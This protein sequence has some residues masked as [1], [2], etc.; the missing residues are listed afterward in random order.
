MKT[1]AISALVLM[2]VTGAAW[3]N[4]LVG[5]WFYVD[6]DP[7]NFAHSVY[8]ATYTAFDAYVMLDLTASAETGF[9]TISFRLDV[10]PGVSSPPSFTNLLPG[11]L[12]IGSWDSGV[13]LASTEC[14]TSFPAPVGYLTLFYLGTPGDIA[15]YD[16]PEYPRW[17][18]NCEDP[19]QVFYYCVYSH[20]G[21]GKEP[22]IG[23]TGDCG[24]SPVEN[25]TWSS[26]K[27]L[28]R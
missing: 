10:T 8:P 3:G 20:G 15:I 2:L 12:A 11:D 7:P 13:T 16:H 17:V 1:A 25:V 9:T 26:L 4:P 18:V 28:Y 6:F 22:E 19:G 23:P 14:I 21:V 27:S 24:G 5:E